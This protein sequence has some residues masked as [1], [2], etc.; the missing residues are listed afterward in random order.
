MEVSKELEKAIANEHTQIKSVNVTYDTGELV[1]GF[2]K[3]AEFMPLSVTLCRHQTVSGE[4][5]LHNI[6]FDTATQIELLY[7]NGTTKLFE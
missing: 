3:T 2:V 7:I 4:N 6:D 1:S 5:P